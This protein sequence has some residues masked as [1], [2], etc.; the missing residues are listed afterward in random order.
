MLLH[1]LSAGVTHPLSQRR[2]TGEPFNRGD[3]FLRSLGQK[4]GLAVSDQLGVDADPA[5]H[6][7]QA[8]GHVLQ[9]LETALALVPRIVRQ[10]ANADV[11]ASQRRGF[12]VLRPGKCHDGHGTRLQKLIANDF[13]P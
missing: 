8:G 1:E 7:R 2:I 12:G 4:T 10:P 3:P 11:G 5:G 6:D 13:Q 9:N